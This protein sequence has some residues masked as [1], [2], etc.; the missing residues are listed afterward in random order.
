MKIT[1]VP[2][3]VIMLSILM[4]LFCAPEASAGGRT[5]KS[6]SSP[7]TPSVDTVNLSA[8]Q[9]K[10]WVLEEIRINT[11][12]VPIVRPDNTEAF[13]IRFDA[14]YVG[15]TGFPNHYRGPYTAGAGNSLSI[16]NMASTMMVALFE[17]EGLNEYEYYGYLSKVKSWA[18]QN[19]KL[20]LTTSGQNGE[21]VVLVYR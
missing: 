15:G 16:G 9:D 20:E 6:A 14:E 21:T 2:V 8:I 17:I 11:T 3:G 18:I 13:T 4:I 10:D 1:F 7:E 19:G 12:T 5:A